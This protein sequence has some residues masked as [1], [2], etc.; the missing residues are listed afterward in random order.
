MIICPVC[1]HPQAQGDECDNCGKK[2][3]VAKIA[4]AVAVPTLAELEQ[5]HHMGG[6][7]AVDAPVMAELDH[8]RQQA[9]PDLPAQSVQDLEVTRMAPVDKV[10]VEAVPELDTGR[11]VD[12]GVR[13][14]APT[15]AVV[16]RYCRNVQAEGMVCDKCGMR[17]PRVRP[18]AAAKGPGGVSEEDLTWLPCKKCRT[19]TRPNKICTVCGTR[20]VAVDA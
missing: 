2:L 20:V 19:P 17:L 18:T 4:A 10:S 3:Q 16:C 15:G 14:A 7:V 9:G 1:E 8:T 13:T 6:R 5:T 11:A 12:D